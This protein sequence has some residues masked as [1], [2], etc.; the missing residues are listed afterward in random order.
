MIALDTNLLARLLLEDDA[1]QKA[2]A[3]AILKYICFEELPA[4]RAQSASIETFIIHDIT[5]A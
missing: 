2:C 5:T 4:A 1:A 3:K